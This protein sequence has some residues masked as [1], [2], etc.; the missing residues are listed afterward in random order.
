M[1]DL[2]YINSIYLGSQFLIFRSIHLTLLIWNWDKAEIFSGK[3]IVEHNCSLLQEI[4]KMD[5]RASCTAVGT[6]L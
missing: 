6:W 2:N 4:F 5:Q 1:F 3:I